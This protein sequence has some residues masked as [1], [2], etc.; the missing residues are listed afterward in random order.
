V[1]KYIRIAATLVVAAFLSVAV[2]A[3]APPKPMKPSGVMPV[4]HDKKDKDKQNSDKKDKDKKDKDKKQTEIR[5]QLISL[6]TDQVARDTADLAA[7][8]QQ[9]AIDASTGRTDR[10]AADAAQVAKA[11]DKLARDKKLL[12][13]AV[14]ARDKAKK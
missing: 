9:L 5:D 14:S 3:A 4:E 11:G 12:D 6:L 1:R 10:F 8:N 2:A 13:Q 7:A